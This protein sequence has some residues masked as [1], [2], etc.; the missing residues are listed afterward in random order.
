MADVVSP[1]EVGK[2]AYKKHVQNQVRIWNSNHPLS[3]SGEFDE[4]NGLPEKAFEFV[5]KYCIYGLA[6]AFVLCVIFSC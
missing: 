1:D 3:L 5:R 6:I 2:E 4:E